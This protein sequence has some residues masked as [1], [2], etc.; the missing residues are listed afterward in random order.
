MGIFIMQEH[1]LLLHFQQSC[2][3][4][5]STGGAAAEK[6]VSIPVRMQNQ[7]VIFCTNVFHFIKSFNAVTIK[8]IV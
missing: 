7:F 3:T 5:A 6:Q 4:I 8:Y 1:Y 2:C